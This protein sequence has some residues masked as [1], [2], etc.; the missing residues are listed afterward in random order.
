MIDDQDKWEWVNVSFSTGSPG[1]L[2]QNPE[3]HKMAVCL[4]VCLQ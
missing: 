2:R 3:S 4:C 1:L